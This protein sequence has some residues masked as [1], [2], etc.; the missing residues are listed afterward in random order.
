MICVSI[1]SVNSPILKGYFF[2]PNL[3]IVLKSVQC[4]FRAK[5]RKHISSLK[6][7]VD[8]LRSN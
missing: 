1:E 6:K 7:G 3:K 2:F 8:L 5:F 4:I